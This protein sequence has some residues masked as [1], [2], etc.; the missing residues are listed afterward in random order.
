MRVEHTLEVVAVC[1]VDNAGDR[2]RVT[3]RCNRTIPVEDILKAVKECSSAPCY[4]EDFTQA[5]SRS[6]VAEV[7]SA[8][9]HSGVWTVVVCGG[10]E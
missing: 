10:G 7:E 6:I 8:G 2:Y 1:P 5:L 4:Q 9:Y 3:V